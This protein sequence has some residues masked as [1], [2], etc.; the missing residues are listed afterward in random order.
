MQFHGLNKLTLL[1]YPGHLA[2]T[3]FTG[4]CNFRCPFCHNASLVLMPERCPIIYEEEVLD[5]LLSRKGKLEGICITGGEPTLQKDLA[6]FIKKV[7]DLGL[8]IKLDTNGYQPDIIEALIRNGLLDAVA[9]DIKNDPK[10][11]AATCGLPESS[12]DISRIEAS[13]SLLMSDKVSHEFRTTVVQELHGRE[14]MQAVGEWLLELSKNARGTAAV[15]SPY[16]LQTFK[17]SGSLIDN[18]TGFHPHTIETM[19]EYKTLLQHY[20]PNTNLR[21]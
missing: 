3:A 14:Q 5:F 4:A 21:G 6:E 20:L 12:F 8:L 7:K 2:C 13:I 16:F 11:Y 18:T 9:M 1:D 19:N 15:T 10:H 17:D